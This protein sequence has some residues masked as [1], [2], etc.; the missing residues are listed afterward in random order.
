M[1]FW[2]NGI[3]NDRRRTE[4]RQKTVTAIA[5][6]Q[7]RSQWLSA[8]RVQTRLGINLSTK[9]PTQLS[10]PDRKAQSFSYL[11]WPI[12]SGLYNVY[13]EL[14]T[15]FVCRQVCLET[16]IWINYW[17]PTN[18]NSKWSALWIRVCPKL[19]E[20]RQ[21]QSQ[22]TISVIL[23]GNFG[24]FSTNSEST[25]SAFT[26]RIWQILG[27]RLSRDFQCLIWSWTS[28]ETLDQR[29]RWKSRNWPYRSQFIAICDMK[30]PA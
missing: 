5:H 16:V 24:Q 25:R 12:T 21:S 19:S 22:S 10:Y 26:L 14:L 1:T 11:V 13:S 18:L 8:R 23:I 17:Y 15:S 7:K 29:K 3:V 30:T 28:F 9:K 4:N 27:N 6:D 2:E 20:G